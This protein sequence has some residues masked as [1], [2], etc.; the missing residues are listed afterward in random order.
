MVDPDS[1]YFATVRIETFGS[2]DTDTVGDLWPSCWSDDDLYTAMRSSRW[3]SGAT[4]GSART[5]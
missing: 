5:I 2:H 1:T 3:T 4:P